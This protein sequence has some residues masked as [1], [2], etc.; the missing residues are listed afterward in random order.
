MFITLIS[1]AQYPKVVINY[2]PISLCN[3]NYK[4]FARILVKMLRHHLKAQS[5]P[6][7]S[8]FILERWIAQTTPITQEVAQTISKKTKCKG[9]QMGIKIVMQN[10]Y[11]MVN[12]IFFYM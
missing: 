2:R 4:I 9:G 12:R 3:V 6:I 8:A 11:D 10:A 5:S 7:Q 1:K